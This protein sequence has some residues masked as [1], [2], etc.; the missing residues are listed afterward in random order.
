MDNYSNISNEEYNKDAIINLMRLFETYETTISLTVE[1]FN[2]FYSKLIKLEKYRPYFFYLYF[3]SYSAFNK[4]PE[5]NRII[6]ETNYQ[7][8]QQNI[9]NLKDH[10]NEIKKQYADFNKYTNINTKIDYIIGHCNNMEDVKKYF[11]SLNLLDIYK[12]NHPECKDPL[13]DY[14]VFYIESDCNL[15]ITIKTISDKI[16]SNEV[17][18]YQKFKEEF[19]KIDQLKGTKNSELKG[20]VYWLSIKK[21]YNYTFKE[22]LTYFEGEKICHELNKFGINGDLEDR[23]FNFQ[24]MNINAIVE[25]LINQLNVYKTKIGEL[26]Q[27]PAV[28]QRIEEYNKL[29]PSS[30]QKLSLENLQLNAP[31]NNES[32]MINYVDNLINKMFREINCDRDLQDK[33]DY[34]NQKFTKNTLTLQSIRNRHIADYLAFK[35]LE[36][37]T[38]DYRCYVYCFPEEQRHLIDFY[39]ENGK[40]LSEMDQKIQNAVLDI[41]GKIID[42]YST[43]TYFNLKKDAGKIS[44][45]YAN[46]IK[47]LKDYISNNGDK[48][49]TISKYFSEDYEL[50]GICNGDL[51]KMQIYYLLLKQVNTFNKELRSNEVQSLKIHEDTIIQMFKKNSEEAEAYMSDKMRYM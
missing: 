5:T 35:L 43:D 1:G 36:L 28:L 7:K 2:E 46:F 16:D 6:L 26:K 20:E 12:I 21:K 40:S 42:L 17:A 8:L 39:I 4:P 25:K 48:D 29:R 22:L 44:G 33:I 47:N 27:S 18:A 49:K 23:M 32:D 41:R 24:N 38:D 11:E 31:T 51:N 3:V 30:S 37:Y 14:E 13:Y 50:F 15:D 19:P 45:D 9:N 34:Y 10:I